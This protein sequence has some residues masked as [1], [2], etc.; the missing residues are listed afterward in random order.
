MQIFTLLKIDGHYTADVISEK[1]G[2]TTRTV[3]RV[4]R[5]LVEKQYIERVGGNKYGYWEIIK[6]V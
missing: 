1:I 2:K 4:I 3:Q 6:K 5:K